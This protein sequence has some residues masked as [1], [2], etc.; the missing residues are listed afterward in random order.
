MHRSGPAQEG[1]HTKGCPFRMRPSSPT[2]ATSH[3]SARKL[4]RTQAQSHQSPQADRTSSCPSPLR[5]PAR[6]SGAGDRNGEGQEA[7]LIPRVSP[8]PSC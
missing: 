4:R 2:Q 6:P 1:T 8:H 3:H 7:A 5:S